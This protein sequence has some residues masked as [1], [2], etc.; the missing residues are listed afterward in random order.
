MKKWFVFVLLCFVALPVVAADREDVAPD[1]VFRRAVQFGLS[2]YPQYSK[3][4]CCG[5]VAKPSNPNSLAEAL[6]ELADSKEKRKEYG[7]NARHLAETQFGRIDLA[8]QFVDFL[9][10]NK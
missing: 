3:E 7:K 9:E 5:V 4:H 8:N 2:N 10:K 6:I 1:H